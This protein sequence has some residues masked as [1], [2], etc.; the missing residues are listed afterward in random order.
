MATG[1]LGRDERQD[2]ADLLSHERRS[3]RRS[4]G[5][6]LMFLAVGCLVVPLAHVVPEAGDARG[7]GLLGL[8]WDTWSFSPADETGLDLRA[9]V[10]ALWALRLA[11][12]LVVLAI[13]AAVYLVTEL[14]SPRSLADVRRVAL[15]AVPAVWVGAAA[16]LLVL[17]VLGGDGV[18]LARGWWMLPALGFWL[19]HVHADIEAA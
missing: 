11:T 7:V 18:G 1:P 2:L 3:R 15:L 10:L 12:L 9:A 13:A 17:P 16:V 19:W 14:M 4:D 8:L 6:V 5:L